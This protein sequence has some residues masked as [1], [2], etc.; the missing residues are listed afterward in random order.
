MPVRPEGKRSGSRQLTWCA[1]FALALS[2]GATLR[3]GDA[4]AAES[5]A[6]ESLE[7]FPQSALEIRSSQGRQWFTIRIADSAARQ[8]QGLMYVRA[9]PADEGMLF[10]QAQPRVMT[11]WMKNTVIPLDLL[12]I[13]AHGRIACLREQ[14]RPLVLDLITCDQAV[15]AV[16]EI[17]GGEAGKRG[18]R[19]GD[20]V[21]HAVFHR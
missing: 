11:F 12:F 10:P 1:S 6:T 3:S 9:L 8:E 14:A 2:L 5:R 20:L 13:T 17:G 18:I 16:L 19:V 7:S 15:K 21:T 4:P